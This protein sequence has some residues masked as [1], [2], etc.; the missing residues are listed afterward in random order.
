MLCPVSSTFLIISYFLVCVM[1]VSMNSRVCVMFVIMSMQGRLKD[2]ASKTL[3]LGLKDKK[4][5]KKIYY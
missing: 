3:A 4:V 2:K 1:F 5:S